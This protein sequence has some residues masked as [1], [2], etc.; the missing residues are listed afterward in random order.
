ML[1]VETFISLFHA[2]TL[3]GVV[4]RHVKK[5]AKYLHKFKGTRM[6]WNNKGLQMS[7]EIPTRMCGDFTVSS[8]CAFFRCLV[9][10]LPNGNQMESLVCQ[11]VCQSVWVDCNTKKFNLLRSWPFTCMESRRSKCDVVTQ[12]PP[13][14]VHSAS[15]KLHN[16]YHR[17]Y[18]SSV[19][20]FLNKSC[21]KNHDLGNE[22]TPTNPL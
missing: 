7:A 22:K 15:H 10:C 13:L 17:K 11:T 6:G 20:N 5:Y 14:S 8:W 18:F 12:L 2:F 9:I 21:L 3:L 4:R 1:H 16:L 19:G